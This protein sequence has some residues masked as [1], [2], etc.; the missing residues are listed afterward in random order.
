MVKTRFKTFLLVASVTMALLAGKS[1]A[2]AVATRPHHSSMISTSHALNELDEDNPRDSILPK[3]RF[4]RT[5]LAKPFVM[6][7]CVDCHC[8]TVCRDLAQNRV[9]APV[10]ST[11][12]ERILNQT[13][14]QDRVVVDVGANIGFFTMLSAAWGARVYSFEPNVHAAAFLRV[15]IALQPTMAQQK[16]HF[17]PNA[18]GAADSE[19]RVSFPENQGWEFGKLEHSG[20]SEASAATAAATKVASQREG[21]GGDGIRLSRLSSIV[22]HP[23]TILKADTE[24]YESSVFEGAYSVL[25][26]VQ[27]V[28][29]EIKDFNTPAKRDLMHRIVVAGGFTHVYNYE[30]KYTSNVYPVG[31]DAVLHDVTTIVVDKLLDAS[32]PFEDFVFSRRVFDLK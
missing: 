27:Y 13:R 12:F 29:V 19:S 28:I 11:I 4:T 5:I 9:W 7:T 21:N 10:E 6:A 8:M 26:H 20:V 24:G 2:S 23:V 25:K 30:E 16:I 18:I 3:L 31:A 14:E 15:N 17:F 22:G 32:I 1:P